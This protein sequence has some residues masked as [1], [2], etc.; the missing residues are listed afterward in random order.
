MNEQEPTLET[1]Y[2]NTDLDLKSSFPFDTLNQ[3]FEKSCCILHYVQTDEGQFSSTIESTLYNQQHASEDILA[4][5]NVIH[6]L[7]PQART[8]LDMCFLRDFNIGFCCG[9]TWGYHHRLE[10]KL[11]KAI[12]DVG[13]SISITLYPMRNPDGSLK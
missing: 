8:E 10:P 3:E 9:D 5:L 1:T 13:C 2:S 4:L 6:S 7:S 11:V 12:A